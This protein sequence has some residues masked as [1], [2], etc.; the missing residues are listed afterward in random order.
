MRRGIDGLSAMV[1]AVIK[2]A[3]GFRSD[4]RVPW[5]ARRR[6]SVVGWP[7]LDEGVETV[8]REIE[9]VSHKEARIG[10]ASSFPLRR[11]GR[12]ILHLAGT[13]CQAAA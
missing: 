6:A 4:L 8:R 2:E 13:R 3:L 5:K 10:G 12:P 11:Q 9:E 7:W 1:E